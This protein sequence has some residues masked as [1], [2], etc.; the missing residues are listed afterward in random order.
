MESPL[1]MTLMG[2]T[3][4]VSLI[5]FGS[6]EILRD[7]AECPYDVI[8]YG[9]WYQLV[10]SGFLHADLG[11][12]FMNMFTL[13]YF[14][15]PIERALGSWRF[16]VVY[17]GSLL[18]GSLLTLLLRH[19]DPSYRALGASGAISGVVFSFVLFAPFS[20]IYI[21]LIPVGIPAILFALGY[22]LLSIFGV[23][24]RLGRIGHE[25][26]L[27]GALGGL[28]LTLLVHPSVWAH[29]LSQF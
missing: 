8:R 14:G 21:F 5:G 19:R 17:F 25:A 6:R 28:L 2:L 1:T 20:S 15:R 22:V 4:L 12:L 13:Y 27:G 9:R 18:A 26:H 3:I 29:F 23:R 11:H 10:S 7:F 16:L 24:R